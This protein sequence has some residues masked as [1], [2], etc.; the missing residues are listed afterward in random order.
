[1][2]YERWCC[3]IKLN[4]YFDNAEDPKDTYLTSCAAESLLFLSHLC[5]RHR[6]QSESLKDFFNL[7]VSQGGPFKVKCELGLSS[8]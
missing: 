2:S 4:S 7:G 3:I 1:M 8:V 6:L 5:Y